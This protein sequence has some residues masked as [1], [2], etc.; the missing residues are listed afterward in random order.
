MIDPDGIQIQ[1]FTLRSSIDLKDIPEYDFNC[2]S[3][4]TTPEQFFEARESCIESSVFNLAWQ[5][6]IC[7]DCGNTFFM[8]FSEVEFFRN[9]ELH[10]P[11]RCRKCRE[12]RKR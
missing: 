2:Y 4:I 5:K 11:K 6:H 12:L 10:L 8:N 3:R 9:K 1:E 7:K